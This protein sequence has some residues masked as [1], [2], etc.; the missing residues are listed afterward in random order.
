LALYSYVYQNPLKLSDPDG[1][2]PIDLIFLGVDVVSLGVAIANGEG[3]GEAAANV[4]FSV[5]GVISP[6][7][8]TGE[9]IKA[10]RAVEHGVEVARGAEHAGDAAR[11]VEKT[12]DA[13]KASVKGGAHGDVKGVPGN[14]S[15]HMPAHSASNLPKDKGPA[16]SMSKED[17]RQT[18]SW[19]SSKEAK[20]YRQEQKKLIEQGKFG[21]A[22]QMDI[23]DVQSK[24]GNKYDGAIQQMQDYTKSLGQ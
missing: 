8:G 14:E 5:L 2:S 11:A 15:H 6:V 4:G 20:A 18:A 10:V 13:E 22:Q 16:I 12:V 24:F 19:G 7:P 9:V 1:R 21:E 3:V 17:H 23:K